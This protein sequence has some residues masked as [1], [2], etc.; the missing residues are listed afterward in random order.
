METIAHFSSV[1]LPQR[2]LP[3]GIGSGGPMPPPET[4]IRPY[5]RVIETPT[6]MLTPIYQ[7]PKTAAV[8]ATRI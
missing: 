6:P 2:K 5:C 7:S 4:P 8:V 1:M 3:I